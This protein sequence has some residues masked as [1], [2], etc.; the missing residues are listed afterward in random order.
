MLSDE[1]DSSNGI[2]DKIKNSFQ[3]NIIFE[4]SGNDKKKEIYELFNYNFSS[5]SNDETHLVKI[6]NNIKL[7]TKNKNISLD[8]KLKQCDNT[9]E[10]FSKISKKYPPKNHSLNKTNKYEKYI[11]SSKF[12]NKTLIEDIIY[13]LTQNSLKIENLLIMN[14]GNNM[15]G[16]IIND[17]VS[18][19]ITLA[20]LNLNDITIV[21]EDKQIN[22]NDVKCFFILS[23]LL[24]A[25][26]KLENKDFNHG[27][28]TAHNIIV[29]INNEYI[30]RE[31]ITLELATESSS[32]T[33]GSPTTTTTSEPSSTTTT[34][35]PLSTT[36]SPTTTTTSEPLS[37]TGGPTTTTTGGPFSEPSST[38]GG[39]L[40]GI[41]QTNFKIKIHNF[42]D[43]S[44][45]HKKI[46]YISEFSKR[47]GIFEDNFTE[48]D[49][50]SINKFYEQLNNNN[51]N[52]I[53]NIIKNKIFKKMLR[54]SPIPVPF[55]IEFYILIISMMLCNDYFLDFFRK[56]YFYLL[57][58]NNLTDDNLNDAKNN[59]KI[60]KSCVSYKIYKSILNKRNNKN[61]IDVPLKILDDIS[62][63]LT[64]LNKFNDENKK[65]IQNITNAIKNKDETIDI[66]INKVIKTISELKTTP[67]TNDLNEIP[68][69][70]IIYVN[71]N[72][73]DK[74]LINYYN[75][76]SILNFN[77]LKRYEEDKMNDVNISLFK[78]KN[79]FSSLLDRFNSQ[80]S[81]N[82]YNAESSDDNKIGIVDNNILLT[83]KKSFPINSKIKLNNGKIYTIIDAK[84]E[85]GKW[86][87]KT[88]REI[89]KIDKIKNISKKKISSYNIP[90]NFI[91]N[92]KESIN[93]DYKIL[94]ND[95]LKKE[96]ITENDIYTVI[97]PLDKIEF[98]NINFFSNKNEIIFEEKEHDNLI[99]FFSNK[100][101]ISIANEKLL[102]IPVAIIELQDLLKLPENI[103]I[104][105]Y[106][107]KKF[108]D[109]FYTLFSSSVI[110]NNFYNFPLISDNQLIYNKFDIDDKNIE[111]I[112]EKIIIK[113]NIIDN[114]KY[115]K[116]LK[117][118]YDEIKNNDELYSIFLKFE[119][120]F[121][122]TCYNYY[123]L[124]DEIK[125]EMEQINETLK[126]S[127]LKIFN[128][129]NEKKN[130]E[131]LKNLDKLKEIKELCEKLYNLKYSYECNKLIYNYYLYGFFWWLAINIKFFTK[132]YPDKQF[133]IKEKIIKSYFSIK[134]TINQNKYDL[135]INNKQ[136]TFLEILDSLFKLQNFYKNNENIQIF[137]KNKLMSIL[138]ESNY[139][140]S[141]SLK[142]LYIELNEKI[143][144]SMNIKD[145][146]IIKE[147]N[148]INV[149]ND[150]N[151][152]LHCLLYALKNKINLE[153]ND[154]PL[155]D[156]DIIQSFINA[157]N[158]EIS[159]SPVEYDSDSINNLRNI[160]ID[161]I[162]F[163]VEYYR[164]KKEKN[165]D[166]FISLFTKVNSEIKILKKMYDDVDDIKIFN[167]LKTN[168]NY[169]LNDFIINIVSQIFNCMFYVYTS[170]NEKQPTFK[171]ITKYNNQPYSIILYKNDEHYKLIKY[172]EN[173]AMNCEQLPEVLKM[174][175]YCYKEP[176]IESSIEPSSALPL[177]ESS[178]A[179]PLI[180]SSSAPPL[181][182]PSSAP[183][184]IESSSEIL[185]PVT[186][187]LSGGG[188]IEDQINSDINIEFSKIRANKNYSNRLNNEIRVKQNEYNNKNISQE[189][190][191]KIKSEIENKENKIK[192][193]NNKLLE[194]YEQIINKNNQLKK[195]YEKDK[196]KNNTQI[197]YIDNEIIKYKS[198]FN[199]LQ[200]SI[201]LEKEK[202][203]K[204]YGII[205][206][207]VLYPGDNPS[208]IDKQNY[209]CKKSFNDLKNEYCEVFGIGC[210]EKN[211]NKKD[212]KTGGTMKNK[213]IDA[214]NT[215]K[216]SM[217]NIKKL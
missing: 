181:I 160:I 128:D 200:N 51:N 9:D 27:K 100:S 117:K 145:D 72:L 101:L 42:S 170:I 172:G 144:N 75:K 39:G 23:Q 202:N 177:I 147:Y 12:I 45:T 151:C 10:I 74:D 16:Y 104:V 73:S 48:E 103:F 6:N 150:R 110:D 83:I 208:I 214:I 138:V 33:T 80:S 36:G 217:K 102:Y 167:Y 210:S 188:P 69:K 183:P 173:I 174:S 49:Y 19:N 191:N 166:Y 25:F 38:T 163:K 59:N 8:V 37:T 153:I 211:K 118:K 107:D 126:N 30:S 141:Y 31:E 134:S 136:T 196:I 203:K 92:I 148:L 112:I 60:I 84:W 152:F 122:K 156:R 194:Y 121:L 71:P 46:R 78:D 77:P 62:F 14:S 142:S 55:C 5:W 139:N 63:K 182:E 192:N 129:M 124:C 143:T 119:L 98:I 67:M 61:N 86:V 149:K 113:K 201:N 40:S 159:D 190:K 178:S 54:Y 154:Y 161:S 162:E 50:D 26:E 157:S 108:I 81:N 76:S 82:I 127:L 158:I 44:I 29:D 109:I 146:T 193:N 93:F 171:N 176:L 79:T 95:E 18:I 90:E 135:I 209:K 165:R 1:S 130:N 88:S 64:I 204:V 184:L 198:E 24:N 120:I 215:K 47:I 131:E 43:S 11:V 53:K 207:L 195:E 34:S 106:D 216:Y 189:E 56:Y 213:I 132:D 179:P 20:N 32:E 111:T 137:R 164:I 197:K 140:N 15:D 41:I 96:F 115:N 2:E 22:N 123:Y 3:K 180:E 105:S 35:E 99:Y 85:P 70:L 65:Y 187:P 94:N 28:L 212:E 89:D 58:D 155:Y 125:E 169:V 7:L 68:D 199:R 13:N 97:K 114:E 205:V 116:N 87:K 4:N 206:D 186:E 133:F 66:N 52:K 185:V 168:E 175:Q 17:K 57:F 21:Y 91:K